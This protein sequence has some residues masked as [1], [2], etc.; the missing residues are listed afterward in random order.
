[1]DHPAGDV[2]L[3]WVYRNGAEAGT[4]SALLEA[5]RATTFPEGEFFL[6]AGGEA[7]E[8]KAIRRHLLDERGAQKPYTSITGHW[9]RGEQNFDH[10]APLDTDR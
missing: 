8:L 4:G 9:K 5:V 6:W 1:M 3:R 10:H 7:V 2:D